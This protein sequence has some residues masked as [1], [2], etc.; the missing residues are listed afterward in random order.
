MNWIE[1][2][3]RPGWLNPKQSNNS[4]EWTE[5]QA[6]NEQNSVKPNQK[7]LRA[8]RMEI[9]CITRSTVMGE[10]CRDESV[11]YPWFF[12]KTTDVIRA[13]DQR[14]DYSRRCRSLPRFAGSAY[15][16]ERLRFLAGDIE[17]E[18]IF[19]TEM[20]WRGLEKLSLKGACNDWN[21]AVC[22][23]PFA[24]L[25]EQRDVSEKQHPPLEWEIAAR[26]SANWFRSSWKCSIWE[27]ISV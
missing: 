4:E 19:E 18:C 13:A 12:K 10:K 27:D 5:N 25:V 7:K 16:S 15:L 23:F 11:R 6:R 9:G 22:R 17:A 20:R 21:T 8:I 2:H 26:S 1:S 14:T 3:M 24:L